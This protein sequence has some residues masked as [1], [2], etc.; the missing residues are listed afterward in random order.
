MWRKEA[1]ELSC[2]LCNLSLNYEQ[3]SRYSAHQFSHCWGHVHS[4]AKG[5]FW[6][7]ASLPWSSFLSAYLGGTRCWHRYLNPSHTYGRSSWSS[8]LQA[9][10]S[11]ACCRPLRK[12]PTP[13]L[14]KQNKNKQKITFFF[15]KK[16]LNEPYLWFLRLVKGQSLCKYFFWWVLVLPN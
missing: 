11:P 2:W 12:I 14:F 9:L 8:R 1:S 10:P 4:R 7:L 6:V 5:S 3:R 15:S 16:K 13:P